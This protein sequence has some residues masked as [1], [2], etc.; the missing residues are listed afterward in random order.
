VT[1]G[2]LAAVPEDGRFAADVL[3]ARTPGNP[4]DPPRM[5]G[6]WRESD[7]RWTH[8]RRL[9]VDGA[10]RVGFVAVATP[11]WEDGAER[12]AYVHAAVLPGREAHLDEVIAHT[13][14]FARGT[15]A[16]HVAAD[17]PDDDA[18]LLAAYDARSWQ[19]GHRAFRS[20]VDLR[21]R[22]PKLRE[23]WSRSSARLAEQG[24]EV[25]NCAGR[26]DAFLHAVLD[27]ANEAWVDVPRTG[28]YVPLG[29]ESLLRWMDGPGSSR[30]SWWV[31]TSEGR[32]IGLSVLSYP[33]ERGVPH[34]DSTAVGPAW[35]GRGVALGLKLATLLQALDRGF[36]RARTENDTTNAP[37]L[38][39]NR[40]VIGYELVP[41]EQEFV[42]KL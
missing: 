27:M 34:T 28:P 33:I 3:S 9:V 1:L 12:Y 24:I 11:A 30:E 10:E 25:I 37:I 36:D 21:A 6:W 5:V 14:S 22:E 13:E 16:E 26:D 38:H 39:L 15:G 20:E 18:P 41:G 4:V 19:R 7:P 8:D 31:A 35:R 17:C 32:P 40:E 29:F 23:L 42:L 2:F